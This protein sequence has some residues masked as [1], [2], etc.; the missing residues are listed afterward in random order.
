MSEI[1]SD[2]HE[3][4][5]QVEGLPFIVSSL[6]R[7]IGPSGKILRP[8][9]DVNGYRRVGANKTGYLVHRL[10]ASAFIGPCPDGH[11]VSHKDHNPSN[12]RRD[13][14]EY[15]T[16]DANV[17]A[18]AAAGRSMRGETHVRA[19]MTE[20]VATE[21]LRRH[22]PGQRM[23]RGVV[24]ANSAKG[25]AREFGVSARSVHCLIRGETWKHLPRGSSKQ[26]PQDPTHGR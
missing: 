8:Y 3:E 16:H 7:V 12:N 14:L 22:E 6:G 15:L 10:V 25:L 1:R 5:R 21:I 26:T 24:Q 11:E 19:A 2:E 9:A 20:A 18:T 4:W 23:G 17:K 13:N